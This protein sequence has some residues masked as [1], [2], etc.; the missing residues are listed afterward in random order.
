MHTIY[1]AVCGEPAFKYK[2][3]PKARELITIE[4]AVGLG[5]RPLVRGAIQYCGTCGGPL[6]TADLL[7]GPPVYNM[8]SQGDMEKLYRVN[9]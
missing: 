8:A 9:G 4:H 1:H 3:E 7:P 2:I 6:A 5:G